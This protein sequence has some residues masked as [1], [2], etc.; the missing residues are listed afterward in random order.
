MSV[1]ISGVTNRDDSGHYSWEK[2]ITDV[3][4]IDESFATAR[5]LGYTRLNYA[6]VTTVSS[7]DKYD[8]IDN[9]AL[10]LQ[11]NGNLKVS[12]RSGEGN[13]EKVLNLSKYEEK[14]EELKKQLDPLGY[15]QQE[16]D[17]LKEKEESSTLDTTAPGMYLKVYMNQNGKQV[18]IADS[19][20]DK[21]S[22]LYQ[23]AEDILNGEYKAK[24]GNYYFQVGYTEDAEIP[25]KG[26]PYALQILQ[27][28]TYKHDYVTTETKSSDSKNKEITTRADS[29][30]TAA[31]GAYGVS[32]ISAGYAAQIQAM[33]YSYAADMLA[34][35]YMNMAS[36][37][38]GNDSNKAASLFSCLL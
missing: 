28:T 26:T 7:L 36:I 35:G 30:L 13:D 18:L 10:Q 5:D 22:K 37:L 31:N 4:D 29:S 3:N 16:L 12:L 15:A 19:S 11:S 14:L 20:A 24:K 6:R 9:Y 32:T 21:G 34:T 23:A 38:S 8:K 33:S 25:R 1:N 17:K 2:K 27:G